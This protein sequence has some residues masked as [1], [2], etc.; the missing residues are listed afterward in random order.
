[1]QTV[2]IMPDSNLSI[3]L[4]DVLEHSSWL[5]DLARR[6]VRDPNAADDLAQSTW[7]A[8]L[9]HRPATD[10]P[11]RQWLASVLRNFARQEVRG[12][13]RRRARE[14]SVARQEA[15]PAA[16]ERLQ[17]AA[18]QREIVDAV[19][20]LN[21]PYR[22][23]ILMRFF[24]ERSPRVIAQELD[25]PVETVH[26]RIARGIERLRTKLDAS[27]GGDR[28]AWLAILG[29]IAD[30]P[31]IPSPSA[32][33]TILMSTKLKLTLA[34]LS[35][36]GALAIWMAID[37]SPGATPASASTAH[38]APLADPPS[39]KSELEL[40]TAS[41]VRESA[42]STESAG[43][44]KTTSPLVSPAPVLVRGKVLDQRGQ[45]AAGVELALVSDDWKLDGAP[46]FTSST[47]GQFEI[48]ALTER[49]GRIVAADPAL[50][51]VL[52]GMVGTG[53]GKIDPVVIVAR[54]IPIAGRVVDEQGFALEGARVV[55][56]IG[57]DFRTRFRE[58]L[59]RSIAGQWSATSD[60]SGA[61][62]IEGAPA[63]DAARL[64]AALA[65]FD[66]FDMTSPELGDRALLVTLIRPRTTDGWVRGRVL[67]AD[68]K[69][70]SG[71]HVSFGID[72]TETDRE[73]A[74]GFDTDAVRSMNRRMN[75]VPTTLIAVQKGLQSE[76]F[77]A[78]MKEGKPDW[79]AFV[80]LRLTRT[81]LDI[82]GR[83]IGTD[84]K[85]L[86]GARVWIADATMFGA[87]GDGAAHVE[88]IH[89]GAEGTFWHYVTSDGEG[90][91]R[92]EGLL[93]REYRV[94][95]MDPST[96]LRVQLGP[97]GA[98]EQDVELRLP[99]DALHSRVAGQV[100]SNDGKPIAGVHIFPMCDAFQAR[101]QGQV[102]GTSHDALDGVVTGDDGRFE[103]KDV[104]KTLVYLRIDGESVIPLEY[105]RATEGDPSD[106]N[107]AF[108]AL[109]KDKIENLTIVVDQ[110]CHLQVELS[111]PAS[112][113][114][115]A[116][117]D[118]G[119]ERV[120]LNTFVGNGRREEDHAPI[121][122]G[123]SAALGLADRGKTIV[124]YKEGREVS[125]SS[126]QLLPGALQ[127]VRL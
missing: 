81:P 67:G 87:L 117:L 102:I 83:V 92:I 27:R 46:R 45:P 86:A 5:R 18:L 75:V 95:A 11:L 10:R 126:V 90:S 104:P 48:P 124:L 99:A 91:F 116:V 17:R 16:D 24:E 118:R 2:P 25:V 96:L 47:S 35:I 19:L 77:D 110:R 115:L 71:A 127:T 97:V 89:A 40:A 108:P 41:G 32:L 100:V 33:G 56:E 70:L 105:C 3:P 39:A 114:E 78:P 101:L 122:D 31:W 6:L 93:D 34:G 109:P 38:A 12:N 72:S 29:P 98:G 53:A 50:T 112:A 51:T 111:D 55:L 73:G 7:L 20:T 63:V 68:A 123:R 43:S 36:V 9:E 85:P 119:G 69:P 14:E 58:V 120:I 52:A 1:M 8:A 80:T 76:R 113:D 44:A 59:D 22:T 88:N 84:G 106:P 65:G 121:V 13:V 37:D 61:F 60:A 107:A 66:D 4:E 26:T 74:F 79:P 28:G 62:S 57:D 82:A 54:R 125:R 64:R 42:A 23:V 30:R 21:E 94:R 103:M 15:E 49:G